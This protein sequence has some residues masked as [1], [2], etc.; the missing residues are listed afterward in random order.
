VYA[1]WLDDRSDPRGEYVRLLVKNEG[2]KPTARMKSLRKACSGPWLSMMGEL[3][4]RFEALASEVE[5]G[6]EDPS[7]RESSAELHYHCGLWWFHYIGNL[8]LDWDVGGL[9]PVLGFLSDPQIAP[10]LFRVTLNAYDDHPRTN[11]TLAVSL[12]PL[13]ETVFPH[14]ESLGVEQS[15]NTILCNRAGNY[16]EGGQ[17][18]ALLAACPRLCDL[19][20]PSAPDAAFFAGQ[21]HPLETLDVHAGYDTQRFI[22]NLMASKRFPKLRRLV[23]KDFCCEYTPPRLQLFTPFAEWEAFFRS[24]ACAALSEIKLDGVV[25]TEA[26]VRALLEIRSED[27]SITRSSVAP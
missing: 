6:E 25:L 8:W 13:A 21:Q 5:R 27:V 4:S 7:W 3:H 26:E 23:Y 19:A 14:L 12:W 18:A 16:Q 20:L 17:A 2:K 10:V 22:P 15:Q 9:T 1:D 24:P 11:G